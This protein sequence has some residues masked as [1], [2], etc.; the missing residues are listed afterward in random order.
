LIEEVG[1]NIHRVLLGSGILALPAM[2]RV[3][4]EL[5]KSQTFGNGCVLEFILATAPVVAD[6]SPPERTVAVGRTVSSGRT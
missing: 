5:A 1:F 3:N 4:L 2:N 6:F